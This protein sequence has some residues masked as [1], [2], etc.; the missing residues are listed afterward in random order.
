MWELPQ[1]GHATGRKQTQKNVTLKSVN[2]KYHHKHQICINLSKNHLQVVFFPSLLIVKVK[3]AKKKQT[4][5]LTKEKKSK[6][7]RDKS[8]LFSWEATPTEL[9]QTSSYKM[10]CVDAEVT[11]NHETTIIHHRKQQ[12]TE[13]Q[14]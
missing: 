8:T 11:T 14:Q 3:L 4:R 9:I 12:L 1:H 13:K 2:I 6:E 5:I 7:Q 10:L